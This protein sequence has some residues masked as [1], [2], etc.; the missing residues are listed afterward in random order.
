[1]SRHGSRTAYGHSIRK[2]GPDTYEISWSWDRYVTGSRL[3]FPQAMSRRTD[4]A[5]ARRFAKKHGAYFPEPVATH[6]AAT[7]TS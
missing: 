2:A 6:S 7:M 4:E 5:G 1:M 3:R